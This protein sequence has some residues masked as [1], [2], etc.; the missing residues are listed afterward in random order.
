MSTANITNLTAQLAALKAKPVP[1]DKKAKR[2]LANQ[3]SLVSDELDG[4]E[5][6]A[7]ADNSAEIAALV[8][9]IARIPT[10]SRGKTPRDVALQLTRVKASLLAIDPKNP[11]AVAEPLP[12]ATA[13]VSK[14]VRK[15]AQ[16]PLKQTKTASVAPVTAGTAAPMT[17]AQTAALQAQVAQLQAQLAALPSG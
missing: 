13:V 3:I 11:L 12:A 4:E 17:P 14:V 16:N 8:A 7:S 15:P 6:D 10:R 2:I 1:T 5:H 9:Q